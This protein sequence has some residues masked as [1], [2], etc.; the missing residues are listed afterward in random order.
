M[1]VCQ[2]NLYN[3][4]PYTCISIIDN[5][6]AI[7]NTGLWLVYKMTREG[8]SDLPSFLLLLLVRYDHGLE[9]R[10]ITLADLVQD[11]A[12]RCQQLNS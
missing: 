5:M 6:C 10:L 12:A 4:L 8:I 7:C 9:W 3:V 2:K 11:F 1:N